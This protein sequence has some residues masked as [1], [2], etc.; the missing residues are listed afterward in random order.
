MT[1]AARVKDYIQDDL[2]HHMEHEAGP[3]C[4]D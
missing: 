2:K 3:E 4:R 1:T